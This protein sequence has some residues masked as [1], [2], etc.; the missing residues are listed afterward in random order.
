MNKLLTGLVAACLGW[1]LGSSALAGHGSRS[2]ETRR[3]TSQSGLD[4]KVATN[5]SH[6]G[7]DHRARENHGNRVKTNGRKERKKTGPVTGKRP[8]RFTSELIKK[9]NGGEKRLARRGEYRDYHKKYGKRFW[10][11]YK[12]SRRYG[13][14]YPGRYHRHWKF[15]CY[16]RYYRKWLFYDECTS[17]YYYFCKRCTCYLPVDYSCQRCLAE[18]DDEAVDPCGE[19]NSQSNGAEEEDGE[20]AEEAPDCCQQ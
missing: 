5:G 11:T 17:C 2:G 16:N 15:Y 1:T 19:T 6:G 9:H 4:H 10:Y 13:W 8:R 18:P 14:K 3:T 7:T 20:E 12:G